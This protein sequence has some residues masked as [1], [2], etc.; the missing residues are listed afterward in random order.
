MSKGLVIKL[1][2]K[3]QQLFIHLL[4]ESL[5]GQCGYTTQPKGSFWCHVIDAKGA[6]LLVTLINKFVLV[7]HLSF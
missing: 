4:Y 1:Q 7:F 2:G 3:Q 5:A 6:V